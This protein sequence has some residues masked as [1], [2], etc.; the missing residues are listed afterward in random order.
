[1]SFTVLYDANVLYPNVLRDVL[2]RLAQTGLVHARWSDR[3]LDETLRNLAADRPDIPT[4]TLVRLRELMNRAVP[5]CLVTGYEA[6]I[7]ALALPD[8]DD[9]H[10]LAAAIRCSVQVIVTAN[11]RDF[12]GT[13]LAQFGIEALHSDEFV[14]DLVTLDG[15][16]WDRA[17]AGV[18]CAAISPNTRF[19][20]S[21]ACQ[22]IDYQGFDLL[23]AVDTVLTSSGRNFSSDP[24]RDPSRT[25]RTRPPEPPT[26]VPGPELS[27]AHRGDRIRSVQASS[28]GR[29]PRW[30][31]SVTGRC[32][33]AIPTPAAV[34]RRRR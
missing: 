19:H 15:R 6:F 30:R 4:D 17:R 25:R 10:V 33:S 31:E 23:S 20:E 26:S 3:I 9:R 28:Q 24:H 16:G 13:E 14:M 7:P 22:V 27:R 21:Y 5:D 18:R 2:I 12:P 34:G 8:E 11:L 1:M 29:R 32:C